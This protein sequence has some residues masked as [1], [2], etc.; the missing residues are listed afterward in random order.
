MTVFGAFIWCS[1]LTWFGARI[2]A[3]HPDLMNDPE[4]LMRMVKQ[5][6]QWIVA[7]VLVLCVLYVL[8]MRLT[9]R[10]SAAS[11]PDIA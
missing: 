6:G 11:A 1:V 9:S 10:S 7:A 4:A 8:V 3:A 5:E 2:T